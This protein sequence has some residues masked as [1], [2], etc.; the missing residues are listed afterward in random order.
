MQDFLKQIPLSLGNVTIMS[1]LLMGTSHCLG[2]RGKT[3]LA[4]SELHIKMVIGI[5]PERAK[6]NLNSYSVSSR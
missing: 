5:S 4:V 1:M 3:Q 2:A 6:I